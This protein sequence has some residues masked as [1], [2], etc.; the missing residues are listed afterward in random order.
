MYTGVQKSRPISSVL[1]CE[2]LHL[3]PSYLAFINNE[4][5]PK[6]NKSWGKLSFILLLMEGSFIAPWLYWLK[7]PS[8]FWS[9][10]TQKRCFCL[11]VFFVSVIPVYIRKTSEHLLYFS[12]PSSLPPP[13]QA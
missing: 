5:S 13:P 6:W 7:T 12:E 10:F 8:N 3:D 1:E 4:P 9:T 2:G 11:F